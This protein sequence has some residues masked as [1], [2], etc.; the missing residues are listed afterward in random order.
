MMWSKLV[1]VGVL[2]G[3]AFAGVAQAQVPVLPPN[4]P[5]E[6]GS[7]KGVRL[8]LPANLD[9]FIRDKATALA[10]GKALFWDIQAGSDGQACASCHFHAGADNRVKNQL[11]PGVLG[12]DT[13]FT[14]PLASGGAGGPNYALAAGDF[15]F[16]RLSD[17]LDRNSAVVFD[18]ND[19]V[20][21][22]G[23]FAGMFIQVSPLV[24]NDA[25]GAPDATTFQVG[26]VAT[27][28]VEGRNTPT[29]INAVFNFRNFWDGRANNVFNGVSPFGRRDTAARVFELQPDGRM[30]AVAIALE[31][32]SLASQAVGPATSD[33]EMS[34]TNRSFADIGRKLLG[35]APLAQQ[36][37]SPTDSVLGKYR[38][39]FS[40]GLGTTYQ[41]LVEQAFQP[42]YWSG[43]QT[44]LIKDRSFNQAEANFSLF[45][46]L[47]IQLYEATLVSNDAPI[48]RYFDGDDS[49]LTDQE[50]R[51]LDVF[52][53]KGHCAACHHGPELSAAASALQAENEEGG[54][55]ERMIM[56]DHEVALYDNG[57]YNTGVRPT[58]ED[59]GVGGSDPFGNPLSFTRQYKQ[60][61]AGQTVFDRFEV[62]PCTFEV[63]PCVPVTD[64][65]ARD[66]VD[67][68]FKTPGLRNVELTGPYF[69][70]GGTA[71]LEQVV[72]F[73]NR[74]GDRRG[75]DGNDTT[76]F[77]GNPSNLD[78]DIG[79]LGLSADEQADLVA[80]LKRPLTDDRVRW[81]KAPFDHPEI[82]VANGAQGNAHRVVDTN[83]DRRADD[84]PLVIPAVGA[85]GRLSPLGPILPFLY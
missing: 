59:V 40:K 78:P 32:S 67:G 53:N 73:Y 60:R 57:F 70:N 72:E 71:T 17:P 11:D 4:L 6:L 75:E 52:Q 79:V 24:V 26:G 16:H 2:G 64:P 50:K 8:P 41:Q 69:H 7:L 74:G 28:K 39:L 81:E 14:S 43:K 30:T 22:Q 85:A 27:R 21:S 76:G 62:E 68:A 65:A 19:V 66:A 36:I 37:V 3:M 61:I 9:N 82:T 34:C 47:A 58:F 35:R 84:E 44:A 15:P 20:S 45:W 31:N 42:K 18:T 13:A 63:E 80:F 49:A 12:K 5:P 56:G 10:L 46:G 25:C 77:A 23:T 33:F 38:R 48:D 51:G 83:A 29:V 55:I 54:L 1:I